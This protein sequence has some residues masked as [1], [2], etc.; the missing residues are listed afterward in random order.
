MDRKGIRWVEIEDK[1]G[2]KERKFVD[3]WGNVV[4]KIRKKD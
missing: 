1:R 3:K 4:K 2:G